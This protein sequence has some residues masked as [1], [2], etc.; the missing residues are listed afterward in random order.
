MKHCWQC[1]ETFWWLKSRSLYRGSHR[2]ILLITQQQQNFH[3]GQFHEC[4]FTPTFPSA[5]YIFWTLFFFFFL[6]QYFGWIH[7]WFTWHQNNKLGGLWLWVA[8]FGSS[9]TVLVCK[10]LWSRRSI[11]GK[12]W[13]AHL[14]D[15]I[16]QSSEQL[17]TEA[18]ISWLHHL[19]LAHILRN[20]R[21][22]QAI[23]G[24]TAN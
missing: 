10:L 6:N 8:D 2:G 12:A 9:I 16:H 7:C 3:E 13:S 4:V 11:I 18:W 20:Q 17:P 22:E 15:L 21:D 5:K 19:P 14:D 1:C 24:R 23:L